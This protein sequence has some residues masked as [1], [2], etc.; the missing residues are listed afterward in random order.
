M[1][2][3]CSIYSLVSNGIRFEC[4]WCRLRR[5]GYV[6]FPFISLFICGAEFI[7]HGWKF[8]CDTTTCESHAMLHFQFVCSSIYFSGFPFPP[9]LSVTLSPLWDLCA[10]RVHGSTSKRHEMHPIVTDKNSC[11]RSN[12]RFIKVFVCLF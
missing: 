3:L 12:K 4:Y 9:S 2:S 6:M 11:R 10:C 8:L 7:F 1:T 5:F